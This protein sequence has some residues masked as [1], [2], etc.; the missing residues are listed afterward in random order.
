MTAL[1]REAYRPGD[2]FRDFCLWDYD[3]VQPPSDGA[4]RQ[5]AVLTQSLTLVPQGDRLAAIFG[6]IRARWGAFNT[7][8]GIKSSGKGLTYELYFY[9]YNRTAR[10]LGIADLVD[11][12]PGLWPRDLA[13]ADDWPWFMMSVEFDPDRLE[14]G[15]G[16]VDLYFE[17]TGGTISAGESRTWD[18]QVLRPKNDYRFYRSAADRRQILTDLEAMPPLPA[19]LIPGR[20]GEEVF[21]VS[22]KAHGSG[23]Y[24]SRVSAAETLRFARETGLHP[25]VT[26]ALAADLARLSSHRFDLGI[27][28]D[29]GDGRGR[30]ARA[31]IYGVF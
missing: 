15:I 19:P 20:Y 21:V 29:A 11:C 14:G 4:L 5:S 17:A 6:R 8:W 26:S 1:A 27:D 22:R 13:R 28:Y 7:V 2:P 18:G 25:G 24:F 12:L 30:L 31:A 9:D 10:R 23:A 16:S 3:P